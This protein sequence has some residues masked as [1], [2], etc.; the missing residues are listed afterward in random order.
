MNLNFRSRLKKG[1]RLI[2]TLV[3]LPSP[4][5]A[6]ILAEVG[7]DWLFLDTEHGVYNAV[8][9]QAMLQAVGNIHR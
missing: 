4:E 5:I 8:E 1:E 7:F 3:S 6:E 9:A 2:G